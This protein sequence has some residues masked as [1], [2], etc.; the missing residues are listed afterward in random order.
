VIGHDRLQIGSR[1]LHEE[2]NSYLKRLMHGFLKPA[3]SGVEVADL[4]TVP[5][6]VFDILTSRDFCYLSKSRVAIYREGVLAPVAASVRKREPL[7]FYYDIGGGYHASIRPGTEAVTFEVGLA[8]LFVLSQ[9]AEFA[10]RV[11]HVYPAGVRFTLVIDNLCALLVNDIPVARTLGYCVALRELIRSVGLG[12]LVDVLVESEHFSPADL[13]RVRRAIHSAPM[14]V[15][16]KQHENVA[17][18]LGRPCDEREV[19]DRTRRYA[20]VLDASDQLLESMIPGVHMTQR[21]TNATICFRPFPGGDSRIQCGEVAMTRN[22]KLKLCPM[23]LTSGNV[24]DHEYRRYRFPEVIPAVI[25]H[26][27]YADRLVA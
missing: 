19:L 25:P 9:A 21:A 22:S 2:L 6:R 3:A 20:E 18:F 24:G 23:L 14:T 11:S 7:G 12:D 5:E 26:V 17:R 15:T 13:E 16:R 1:S 4:E 10:A 27:T 8:E